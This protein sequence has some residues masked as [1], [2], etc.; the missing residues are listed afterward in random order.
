MSKLILG[1]KIGMT[2]IF[3][4]QGKVTPVTVVKA[5][6]MVV[7]AK[8]EIAGTD[9]YGIKVGFEPADKQEKGDSVR[10]RGVTKSQAGVFLKAGLET[11]HR[12]VREFRVTAEEFANYEVGQVIDF[13]AFKVDQWI[14]VT[15]TSRGRGFSGVMRRHGFG[16]FG[17]SHGAHESFRGGGSIGMSAWP[18]RVLKGKKM[19]GQ[20]GNRRVT[21]QNLKIVGILEEDNCYLIKGAV[22]GSNG[23]IV[24]VRPAIKKTRKARK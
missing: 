12:H 24:M 14:D 3:D 16:G 8:R 1:R 5:G 22:P 6:P 23:G 7:V 9:Y 13:T 4:T 20:F 11:P 15:G 19:A 10:W 17:S 21:I 18:S 2:Q